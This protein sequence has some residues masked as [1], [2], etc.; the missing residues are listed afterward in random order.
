MASICASLGAV[1]TRLTILQEADCKEAKEAAEA[2]AAAAAQA[3]KKR[4]EAWPWLQN[5][6]CL[7]R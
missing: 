2:E 7:R 4:Q 6:L 1:L 5:Q 3:D